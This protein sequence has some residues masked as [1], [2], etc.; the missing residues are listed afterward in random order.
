MNPNTPEPREKRSILP[1]KG[2]QPDPSWNAWVTG[3]IWFRAGSIQRK[4][5]LRWIRPHSSVSYV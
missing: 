1:C 5:L 4:N 2:E 3:P